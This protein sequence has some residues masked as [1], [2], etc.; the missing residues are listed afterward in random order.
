M[1]PVILLGFMVLVYPHTDVDAS[2]IAPFYDGS[3]LTF[4]LKN[5]WFIETVM[6]LWLKYLVIAISL[7]F[8]A[9]FFLGFVKN[10]AV[11]IKKHQRAFIWTFVSMVACTT[12]ISILKHMSNHSCPWD[13]TLYGGVQPHLGLFDALPLGAKAGHCF[14][15]GHASAG[16]SLMAIYFGFRDS[17]PGL[18]KTA[19]FTGLVAGLVMGWGQM[20]RGAHFMSHNVW[21]GLIVWLLLLALY[22]LWPP[23]TA[24]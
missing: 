2:L 13:L 23:H 22:L 19:L 16:F 5:N 3:H 21:T 20:M 8:L 9:L 24:Q 12:I 6:H 14:P 15:G 4:P 11:W 17:Q 7:V 10:K 18:A 1:L